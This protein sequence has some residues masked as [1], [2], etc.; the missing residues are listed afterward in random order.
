[1]AAD[2]PSIAVLVDT[3]TGWGRRLIRGVTSYAR[4]HGPWHLHVEPHGQ[5]EYLRLP[6][7]WQGDGIIAR[8]STQRMVD[9]LRKRRLPIVNV[10]SIDLP[11]ARFPRVTTNYAAVAKLAVGHFAERGYRR[12]A[13]VGPLRF[14]YARTLAD[15]FGRHVGEINAACEFVDYPQ[16]STLSRG[17]TGWRQRLGDW[18]AR[19]EKPIGILCWATASGAHVI[20]ACRFR[21]IAVPDDV[22]VLGGDDDPLICN[23]TSPPMSAVVT[24][25]AQIGHHAAARIE[26]LIAGIRD[27]GKP[28]LI[29]PIRITTRQSTD[30]ISIDDLELRQ[31]VTFIRQHAFEPI[32]VDHVADAVPMSRRGLERKFRQRFDRSPLEDIRRIRLSRA[33]ELLAESD[34]PI[35]KV[36]GMSGFGTPEYLA[37]VFKSEYGITPLRYRSRVLAR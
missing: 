12:F 1:M 14:G 27:S 29:D 16:L 25:S 22:A 37:T 15:A 4:K 34:L 30:A 8:L 33:R 31:A 19:V 32:T 35:S 18:L 24:A 26:R 36:A 11:H 9:A 23:T 20:D 5:G 2:Q 21:G 3:A 17:W 7:G 13:Y 6:P 28:E 10:S